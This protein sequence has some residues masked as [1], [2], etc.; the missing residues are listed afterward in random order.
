MQTVLLFFRDVLPG[1]VSLT[2]VA[3]SAMAIRQSRKSQLSAAYF[4]E[5]AAVYAAY[6]DSIALFVFQPG[7]DTRNSLSVSLYRIRLYASDAVLVSSAAVYKKAI[8]WSSCGG[9]TLE[10]DELV[11][12]MSQQMRDDLAS[13]DHR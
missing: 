7:T 3:V 12:Q 11:N 10:L 2:A 6:L 4:N 5:K 8:E 9:S 13:F 1:L